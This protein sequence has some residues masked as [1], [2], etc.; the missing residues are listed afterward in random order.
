MRMP[1]VNLGHYEIL[2]LSVAIESLDMPV[3]HIKSC[4]WKTLLHVLWFIISFFYTFAALYVFL[5][6]LFAASVYG[7]K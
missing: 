1:I 5:Y 4:V 2:I 6:T 7:N 3:S